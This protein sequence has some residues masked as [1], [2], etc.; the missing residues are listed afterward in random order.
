MTS[1]LSSI[2][3]GEQTLGVGPD[4]KQLVQARTQK[5]RARERR[6]LQEAVKDQRRIEIL[7]PQT[8]M[9]RRKG[10][11]YPQSLARVA[12]TVY[13]HASFI[14]TTHRNIVPTLRLVPNIDHVQDLDS[15]KFRN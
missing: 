15:P 8:P 5:I 7:V 4:L 3:N 10:E 11:R 1:T 12:K 6:P 14:N 13:L 2:L 9:V